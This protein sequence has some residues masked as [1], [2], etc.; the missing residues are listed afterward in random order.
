MAEQYGLQI[1]TVDSGSKNLIE[2][3]IFL[4]TTT[5]ISSS[6]ILEAVHCKSFNY[7]PRDQ[8]LQVAV[9]GVDFLSIHH[10]PTHLCQFVISNNRD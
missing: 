10:T 4:I 2:T 8:N 9:K 5:A 6:T 7:L 1:T 3:V